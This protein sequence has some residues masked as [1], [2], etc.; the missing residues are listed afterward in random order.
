[1]CKNNRKVLQVKKSDSVFSLDFF[2]SLFG[3]SAF[4]SPFFKLESEVA[5]REIGVAEVCAEISS[6]LKF[7][8][9]G[10]AVFF[11]SCES[12]IAGSV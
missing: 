6:V 2:K 4:V 8:K 11:V 7:H 10:R 12:V 3:N 5:D 9:K 1:M